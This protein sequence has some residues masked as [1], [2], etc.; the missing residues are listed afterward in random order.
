[1]TASQTRSIGGRYVLGAQI[2]RGGMGAVWLARDEVLGRDVAVKRIGDFPGGDTPGLVR[3]QREAKLAARLNHPHVVAVFDF[4]TEG[5]EQ[6][7]V[8][9]HVEGTD[10]A[11]LV[12]EYGALPPEDAANV[13][14]QV[15][16]ALAAAHT[17][18]IVHRDVKPS[19]ILITR[20]GTAKLADFGI[21]RARDSTL[22][23]SGMVTGSP[24]YLAPEVAAGQP[25]T[26][27]SDVW[28]LGASLYQALTG[29]P[30]Y[31]TSD[32]VLAAMYQI[33]HEPPPRLPDEGWP[34]DLLEHTMATDPAD[35]WPMS[36]VRDYLATGA[37]VPAD[38]A[39]APTALL[40]PA[41]THAATHEAPAARDDGPAERRRRLP[42][43][44]VALVVLLLAAGLA[45]LLRPDPSPTAE[46]DPTGRPS[47]KS[48]GSPS[49]QAS[50]TADPTPDPTPDPTK[51]PTTGPT[52]DTTT[53]DVPT[54][55]P[56]SSAPAPNQAAAMRAFIQQYIETAL[57]DPTRSWQQ[58]S[59]R[60]QQ[61]CCNASVGS[62]AGYWNTIADASL[63]DVVAD[64]G[65]MQVSYVITWDP[66]DRPPEDENVTLGLVRRG[67]GYL[68]DYEL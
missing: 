12:D 38:D 39:E 24:A 64:P 62:Y 32:N 46:D 10:L 8:M 25:A 52:T 34:A 47:S 54:Q 4:V 31:D 15:A 16:E 61:E 23:A 26:E 56:T 42:L 40:A 29:R 17:A 66:T 36:R 58:L 19:N 18:A 63:R 33:V 41:A 13:L 27:A 49:G 2:G 57:A 65:T 21:A 1:M 20:D 51:D 53:E 67:G 50:R 28:S 60:F 45:W 22:T 6:W 9:E 3:A 35:R 37:P 48:S 11:A 30:P 14:R 59:P 55:Q 7:L 5:D 44:L 43:L 68:I